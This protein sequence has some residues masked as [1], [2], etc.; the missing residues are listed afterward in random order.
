MKAKPGKQSEYYAMEHDVY[1]KLHKAH[2]DAGE[3]NA[4]WFLSRM[5]PNGTDSEFDFITLNAYPEKRE[6]WT[7]DSKLAETALTADE[8]AK[9]W[10][11]FDMR[12][13]V[14]SEIWHPVLHTNPAKK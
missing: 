2:I 10:N 6:K 9:V 12:T 7:S 1:K 4:W 14:R 5:I 11:I 3:M 13:M 8:R